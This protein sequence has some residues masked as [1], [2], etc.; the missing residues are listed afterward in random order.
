M[1][2]KSCVRAG[3]TVILWDLDFGAGGIPKASSNHCQPGVPD[4]ILKTPK[5]GFPT[6]NH[7]YAKEPLVT[8]DMPKDQVP[9]LLGAAS[10]PRL[11][12]QCQCWDLKP[13]ARPPVWPSVLSGTAADLLMA[14]WEGRRKSPPRM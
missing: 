3:A 6:G 7:G 14:T 2:K 13:K 4:V 1:Q 8:M 11:H 9:R 12:S 10:C 5:V